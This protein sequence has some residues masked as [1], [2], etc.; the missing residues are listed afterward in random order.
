M[1]AKT[2]ITCDFCGKDL[3][4]VNSGFDETRLHVEAQGIY[5]T[6]NLSYGMPVRSAIRSDLYFC[7]LA[8]L[9]Q[10]VESRHE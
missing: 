4:V 5:N 10:W 1:P 3:T 6:S 2:E 8:C 7:D 9:R